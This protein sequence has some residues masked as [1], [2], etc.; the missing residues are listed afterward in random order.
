MYDTVII[1]GGVAAFSA[2]LYAG[3]F[4][5]K[6]LLIGQRLG[7]TTLETDDIYNYPGFN[8]ISGMDLFNK[9][10]DHAAE[11]DIEILEKR[12]DSLDKLKDH[13]TI[14]TKDQTHRAK[15]GLSNRAPHIA[16]AFSDK[17]TGDPSGSPVLLKAKGYL[18][19]LSIFLAFVA[20]IAFI[21][22]T[23]GGL[24]IFI[25]PVFISL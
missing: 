15:T 6:T 20:I 22:F 13:F 19:L 17:R 1:G 8:K 12:A 4:Q 9:I 16:G 11:Y 3:R 2:A 23:L 14:S 18:Q 25:P 5:L 24:F 7:G 10:K 21:V